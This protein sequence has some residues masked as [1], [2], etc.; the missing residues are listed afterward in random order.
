MNNELSNTKQEKGKIM[1]EQEI[2]D[3]IIDY[4]DL[5][6]IKSTSHRKT[7]TAKISMENL[8]YTNK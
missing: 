7:F 1:L 6:I 3:R 4:I 8:Y 2:L 5:W